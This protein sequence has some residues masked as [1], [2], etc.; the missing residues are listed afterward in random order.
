[1][2]LKSIDAANRVAILEQTGG[3][4]TVTRAVEEK[5]HNC[6]FMVAKGVK[7]TE[8]AGD[9]VVSWDPHDDAVSSATVSEV[10][11]LAIAQRNASPAAFKGLATA[12]YR[13][14][15]GVK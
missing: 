1:M 8:V 12:L 7:T 2:R 9:L 3:G 14:R 5:I 6:F 13:A 4:P 15:G 11:G 10:I